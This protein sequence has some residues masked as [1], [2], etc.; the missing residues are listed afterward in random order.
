[1]NNLIHRKDIR[2]R[3]PF[4]VTDYEN[5]VYYL[6]GTTDQNTWEGKA[7]GFNAYRSTDL[8]NWEGPFP[9]FRP[10]E[11]FWSD[12]NFWAPEVYFYN[13]K[14][15]MFA[16]FKAENKYRGTQVLSA[17]HPL[18]PFKPITEEPVTP[19]DWECLDGTLFI[20]DDNNPWMVFCH[21]WIQVKDGKIC[22]MQ[23]S[24]DLK[25]S[26]SEPITL[27]S[28]SEAKWPRRGENYVT[29]GPY[30][31]RNKQGELLMIWSSTGEQGYAIGI[32]RS[33]SGEIQGPWQHEEKPLFAQNGG[34]GMLFKTFNDEL[35]LTFHEP[36]DMPNE[37]PVFYPVKEVDGLLI[38]DHD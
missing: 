16:S 30:L 34:H 36:N 6:Y 35:M 9:V 11:N 10:D 8:E 14:Y 18:G 28:A 23:L 1:M 5:K 31:Y 38:L 3:D 7:E 29:D 22:A 2:I 25:K 32:A 27:F 24:K 21:E 17:D 37:R 19:R 33:K 4:V 13:G 12:R 20:D 26:I 15:I